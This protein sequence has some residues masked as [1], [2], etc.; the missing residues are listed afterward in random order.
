MLA[1]GVRGRTPSPAD[2][3]VRNLGAMAAGDAAHTP[4]ASSGT[5]AL[6]LSKQ[7]L[8]MQLPSTP[9][10]PSMNAAFFVHSPCSAHCALRSM[11][12]QAAQKGAML[13]RLSTF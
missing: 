2:K 4:Q 5:P 6:R 7:Q 9:C 3:I 1:D 10:S 13:R 8:A 12:Q 11:R